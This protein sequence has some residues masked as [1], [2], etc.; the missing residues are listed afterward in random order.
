MA[1][2]PNR[3][4]K[5]ATTPMAA[6]VKR[7]PEMP[8]VRQAEQPTPHPLNGGAPTSEEVAMVT[9]NPASL[10]T[11]IDTWM[12]H[13]NFKA[14]MLTFFTEALQQGGNTVNTLTDQLPQFQTPNTTALDTITSMFPLTAWDIVEHDRPFTEVITR[15]KFM[16]NTALLMILAYADLT[17]IESAKK[18]ITVYNRATPSITAPVDLS[19]SASARSLN[20]LTP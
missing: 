3:V 4:L 10:K 17:P 15:R 14:K 2:A 1:T 7:R 6:L 13:P 11:L 19:D 5:V 8:A 16:A 12:T 9:A 18:E 20:C